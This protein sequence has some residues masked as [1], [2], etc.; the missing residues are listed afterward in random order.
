MV[1]EEFQGFKGDFGVLCDEW[2]AKLTWQ[3]IKTKIQEFLTGGLHSI[4]GALI[5][6]FDEIWDALGLPSLISLFTLDVGALIEGAI[7]AL[8]KKREE[9]QED[10]LKSVGDAR[11]KL[12]QE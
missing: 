2:K 1:A 6:K 7:K 9:I 5:D 10:F 8:R 3:Y 12:R 4:F 11:E